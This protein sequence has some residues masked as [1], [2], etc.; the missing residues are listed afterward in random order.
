MSSTQ[1]FVRNDEGKNPNTSQ[2]KES[3][4]TTT[5]NRLR[6]SDM[7]INKV[8][9]GDRRK[10]R[11]SYNGCGREVPEVIVTTAD[12]RSGEETISDRLQFTK[13]QEQQQNGTLPTTSTIAPCKSG[14]P[15]VL[16]STAAERGNIPN[17][18][19]CMSDKYD[20]D[21]GGGR[22]KI[23]DE[24]KRNEGVI[25]MTHE[26]S[27]AHKSSSC[28]PSSSY[29][30]DG[31]IN[32]VAKVEP[33]ENIVRAM[34]NVELQAKTASVPETAPIPSL[35]KHKQQAQFPI[36]TAD[37]P[38]SIPSPV[39]R[40]QRKRGALGVDSSCDRGLGPAFKV[41]IPSA[42]AGCIIGKGGTIISQVQQETGTKI[43]LSQNH[44]FFPGTNDR[45]C[46]IIGDEENIFVAIRDIL[47]RIV[48]YH[49][50]S[51]RLTKYQQ[52]HASQQNQ[53]ENIPP[54][55]EKSPVDVE[56]SNGID[57]GGTEGS[58]KKRTPG[59]CPNQTGVVGAMRSTQNDSVLQKK[60]ENVGYVS[61]K[62]LVPYA[63][64][65]YLLREGNGALKE[66]LTLTSATCVFACKEKSPVPHER[67]C[68]LS[69]T[70]KEVL[71]LVQLIFSVT[72]NSSLGGGYIHMSTAYKP[73]RGA[74]PSKVGTALK[75]GEGLTVGSIQDVKARDR[76]GSPAPAHAQ[77]G[78][79]QQQAHNGPLYSAG[80]YNTLPQ[81]G[82]LAYV[83]SSGG[84]NTMGTISQE[85]QQQIHFPYFV[86]GMPDP[87]VVGMNGG[88]YPDGPPVGVATPPIIQVQ[89]AIP[90]FLVG[91][92]L[93]KRGANVMR[94]Q[95]N[96]RACIY[97]SPRGEFV[98]GTTHRTVRIVG[99][100]QATINAQY[101]INQCMNT[102]LAEAYNPAEGSVQYQQVPLYNMQHLYSSQYSQVGMYPQYQQEHFM[103]PPLQVQTFCF[104][105][106]TQAMKN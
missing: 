55:G 8:D 44:K 53:P 78:Q 5:R 2:K 86:D 51:A 66:Y 73:C 3:S 24:R 102:A 93:G 91:V 12:W 70:V 57:V 41:L 63:A 67:V 7:V 103:A 28:P 4:A 33:V 60:D 62:A 94:I 105:T 26:E 39:Q 64:A 95:R 100:L 92:V 32:D 20:R 9:G 21:I 15:P 65:D 84:T 101:L 54:S 82:G 72:R 30:D 23:V 68:T 87:S 106:E 18:G 31:G 99:T 14:V 50:S 76:K 22:I 19:D 10:G 40:A 27:A 85:Q 104:S 42:V 37:M 83:L 46:L 35:G 90:D 81:D 38:S 98:P 36:P 71:G 17:D 80:N 49:Q 45:V 89:V 58:S 59:G 47:Q 25:A 79:Y 16:D 11:S 34:E 48:F 97:I 13:Q 69:G 96:A 1:V 61:I 52:Q 75:G 56:I 74:V 29:S 6:G 43:K 88:M 77:P